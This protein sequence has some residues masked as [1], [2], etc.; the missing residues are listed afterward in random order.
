MSQLTELGDDG[1][2]LWSVSTTAKRL[3][4][5]RSTVWSWIKNGNLRVVEFK[6]G[7]RMVTVESVIDLMKTQTSLQSDVT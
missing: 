1:V 4:R 3:G 5:H 7:R 6:H 2:L